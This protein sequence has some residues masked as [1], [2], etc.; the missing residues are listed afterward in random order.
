M[1]FETATQGRAVEGVYL[2]EITRGSTYRYTSGAPVN[3]LGYDWVPWP[4]NI[5]GLSS[6][7]GENARCTVGLGDKDY[8]WTDNLCACECI[9]FPVS[10]WLMYDNDP[11]LVFTGSATGVSRQGGFVVCECLSVRSEMRQTPRI[12]WRS[13]YAN[14]VRGQSV[15]VGSETFIF[16]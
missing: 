4:L 14:V 5:S 16:D 13:P 12:Y 7:L 15:V 1:T 9:V 2:V 8:V 6:G 10:V 3:V 11:E